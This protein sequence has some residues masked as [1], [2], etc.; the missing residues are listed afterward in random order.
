MTIYL[1][2]IIAGLLIYF[3]WINPKLSDYKKSEL[4][5]LRTPKKFTAIYC[6]NGTYLSFP[7]LKLCGVESNKEFD[8]AHT[9]E[10]V[11]WDEEE[12]VLLFQLVHNAR[13]EI[14]EPDDI[15][16]RL[17]KIIIRNAKRVR[18]IYNPYERDF[19]DERCRFIDININRGSFECTEQGGV[20]DIDKIRENKLVQLVELF[21]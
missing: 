8:F 10:K 20:F 1:L 7:R 19:T 16:E 14:Y 11:S 9:I 4:Q 12:K 17:A 18:W 2:I 3:L 21:D 15:E 5:K 13:L 6:C